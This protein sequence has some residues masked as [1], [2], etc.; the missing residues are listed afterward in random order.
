MGDMMVERFHASE[1]EI[2]F[3]SFVTD[4]Y[5]IVGAGESLDELQTSGEWLAVDDPVDV[6][7]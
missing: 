6:R 2:E 3:T 4:D 1:D 7:P 5:F